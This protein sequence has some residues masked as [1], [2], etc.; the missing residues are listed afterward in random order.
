MH[1]RRYRS[2]T[3]RDA[4]AE[5]RRDLGPQALVLSTRLVTARGW[6]GWMGEREVEVTAAADRVLDEPEPA[7]PG[8]GQPMPVAAEPTTRA[9]RRS[10]AGDG[11]DELTARLAAT[12][13]EPALSDL[14]ARHVP[15]SGRRGA[16]DAWLR[17]AVA[18]VLAEV[19]AGAEARA[20]IELFVGPPG[21]GKTTTIAKIAALA[22][23]RR[24]DRLLLVSADGYRPGA[25]D[26]LRQYAEI[27]GT[28]FSAAR[29]PE[30]LLEL[31]AQARG[32]VL[33]DTAGRSTRGDG[34]RSA[35]L[36]A[37]AR[38]LDVRTHLVVAADSSPRA[39]ERLLDLY[40]PFKP[41]R[42]V[43]TRVDEVDTVA[44]LVSVAH[45]RHV[46]VSFFGTGQ[47]VPEDL[48][49]GTPD[50]LTTHVLGA[51]VPEEVHA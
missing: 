13:L 35:E 31:V 29:S 14:I 9:S 26:Q 18:E 41:G 12:G 43:L 19:S 11:R 10:E 38:R 32:P 45:R 4:L 20:P 48:A 50:V 5:A 51:T 15:R 36:E 7:V 17:R 25:I 22:R 8:V 1:L 6:R 49:A 34:H 16:D 40:Q 24:G 2:C 37:L 47:R 42:I 39:F 30:Y 33:V 46:M 23:V 28:R 44:P 21:A 27:V 3:V